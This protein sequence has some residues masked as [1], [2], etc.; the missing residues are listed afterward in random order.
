MI[1]FN[2]KGRYIRYL[3]IGPLVFVWS[4]AV[5]FYIARTKDFEEIFAR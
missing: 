3:K 5:G 2:R 4:K 1:Q